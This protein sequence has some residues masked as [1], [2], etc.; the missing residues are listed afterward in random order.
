MTYNQVQR[1]CAPQHTSAL[2]ADQLEH[3]LSA[4]ASARVAL[5]MPT[6]ACLPVQGCITPNPEW[7]P[8]RMALLVG[9]TGSGPLIWSAADVASNGRGFRSGRKS[10]VRSVIT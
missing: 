5:S 3:A 1:G 7:G 6:Q 4:T 8:R 10:K 2:A 9:P